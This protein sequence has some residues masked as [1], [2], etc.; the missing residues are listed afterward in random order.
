MKTVKT[1]KLLRFSAIFLILLALDIIVLNKPE[2]QILG[3]LQNQ[4]YLVPCSFFSIS[5]A[6]I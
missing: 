4:V 1:Y 6:N 5:G 3:T 2:L